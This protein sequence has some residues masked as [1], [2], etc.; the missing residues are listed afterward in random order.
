M[1]ISDRANR[2]LGVSPEELQ[3]LHAEMPKLKAE[4]SLL[5][6]VE[7][8][9]VEVTDELQQYADG[10]GQG[11]RV[12]VPVGA[13]MADVLGAHVADPMPGQRK[14]LR[15]AYTL[16]GHDCEKLARDTELTGSGYPCNFISGGGGTTTC[17]VGAD[18]VATEEMD[19]QSPP[20]LSTL[21]I[22][23]SIYGHPRN[24]SKTFDVTSEMSE[25]RRPP[26]LPQPP[27][28]TPNLNP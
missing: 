27:N 1:R 6:Q 5:A 23:R 9:S 16:L 8:N 22:L 19:V 3:K 26:S 28:P 24:S 10:H 4:M 21:Q 2:G 18:G 15:V 17:A 14:T 12:H 7:L 13:S 11:R 25:C 20:V